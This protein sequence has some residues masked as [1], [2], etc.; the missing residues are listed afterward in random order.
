MV[1]CVDIYNSPLGV[2]TL[3]CDDSG[4]TSLAFADCLV[5]EPCSAQNNLQ[6][7]VLSE[8]KAWLDIY[9]SGKEPCYTPKISMSCTGFLRGVLEVVQSIRYGDTMTYMEI[10]KIIAHNTHPS[11]MLPRAVGLAV[12][13][14]PILLIVP[15]H[16]VIGSNG[17]LIGYSGGLDKKK[18]L[19]EM[20]GVYTLAH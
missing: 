7:Q 2:I 20:E 15:C 4:I 19:L 3:S 6:A 13:R 12:R 10:A 18:R 11:R 1:V 5:P 9:F 16:R 17:H 8:A 14:N